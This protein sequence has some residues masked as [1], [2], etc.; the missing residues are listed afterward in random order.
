[1][2]SQLRKVSGFEIRSVMLFAAISLGSVAAMAQTSTPAAPPSQA[3]FGAGSGPATGVQAAPTPSSAGANDVQAAFDR[4]DTNRDGKLS[5][6][7]A[8]A[9]PAVSSNFAQ[10]DADKNGSLSRDE[11]S[12][13]VQ[14]R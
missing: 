4:A 14:P 13:A 10:I 11:F 5:K 7:E 1:M 6:K 12:K 2:T 9:L 3:S 8:E